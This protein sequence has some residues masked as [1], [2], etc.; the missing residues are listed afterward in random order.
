MTD[1]RALHDEL[2]SGFIIREYQVMHPEF[3]VSAKMEDDASRMYRDTPY[4]HMR[5]D[6]VVAKVMGI[7]QKHV[8]HVLTQRKDQLEAEASK[9]DQE[10]RKEE[11]KELKRRKAD[12]DELKHRTE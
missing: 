3:Q 7:V 8:D 6:S 12:L 4:F 5:V 2:L 10:G 9:F 1:L 11:A